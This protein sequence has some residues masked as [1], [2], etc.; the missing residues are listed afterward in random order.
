MCPT[1]SRSTHTSKIRPVMI[2][3]F[4]RSRCST[5]PLSRTQMIELR[6]V[7]RLRISTQCK[8]TLTISLRIVPASN[9]PQIGCMR[10]LS[11]LKPRRSN[12]RKNSRAAKCKRWKM[13]V[14]WRKKMSRRITSNLL[15]VIRH[16]ISELRACLR[17]RMRRFRQLR[18]VSF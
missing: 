3:V 18:T 8:H 14:R 12:E 9:S 7:N 13:S 11:W 10:V 16:Y 1:K 6:L 15:S 17:I 5:M 2:A 4:V